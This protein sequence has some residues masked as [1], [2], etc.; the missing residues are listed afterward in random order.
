M[1]AKADGQISANLHAPVS[2]TVSEVKP[3]NGDRCGMIILENDFENK[4]T[5]RQKINPDNLE[6]HQIL[7]IIEKAGIV[8][9][10]GAQFPTHIKYALQGSVID[11]FIINGTECEPYLTSDYALM[12]AMPEQM[13]KAILSVNKILQAKEIVICI[14]K[15]NKDIASIFNPLL[16]NGQHK[17]IRLKILPDQYP[18]GGELQLIKSVTGKEIPKG[19][20]PRNYGIVMSNVGT[21]G[22]IYRAVFEQKPLT[23]RIITISGEKAKNVGSYWVKIGTPLN[24][25]IKQSLDSSNNNYTIVMGGPMMGHSVTDVETPIIKGSS[26]VLFLKQKKAEPNNCISCGYCIDVCPMHL[27]PLTF[28]EKFRKG[29]IE[30][31]DKYNINLCIECSA[32]E[33]I[34][35]SNVPLMESIKSGKKQLNDLRKNATK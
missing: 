21:V 35:P 2:G 11:T 18:Q 3:T 16:A 27:M 14:E 4:E 29:K 24:A 25:I 6:G 34:C 28:A 9:E 30:Q 8:G 33:Y 10:G 1:I 5:E 17:N 20:L 26:A 13:L 19:S 31:L 23:E 15:H 12:R 22:A 32:C 7:D